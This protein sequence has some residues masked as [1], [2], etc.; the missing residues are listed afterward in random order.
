MSEGGS[1]A[2]DLAAAYIHGTAKDEQARL[3]EL[4]RLI[5]DR[6]LAALHLVPGQSILDVGSG[7]GQMSRAMARAVAQTE[8]FARPRLLGI[9][10]SAEQLSE[11]RRQA[12]DDGEADRVEF[13]AGDA[14]R[15]PLDDPEWGSFDVAHTRFLLEHVTSPLEVVRSMVRA[16][17]PGGRLLLLDDDHDLL[18]LWPE[19]PGLSEVWRAYLRSY[20]RIG[21][22]PYIGRRLVELLHAAGAEPV[23]CE[24]VFFGACS[25]EAGFVGFV[26]NL[27]RILLGA[28]ETT[29][30]AGWIDGAAI[31]RA[32]AELRHWGTRPDAAFWY[33]IALAEGRRPR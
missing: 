14:L 12:D 32:V 29:A 6:C 16:V 17:R 18:R 24:W 26:E 21:C 4:N 5:N 8:T 22:D 20:D 19:V 27:A 2:P 33:A 1:P 13:R 15:L 23:R 3:T 11:A 25:G 28:R 31:D 9:E 10:S 30:T 7:L